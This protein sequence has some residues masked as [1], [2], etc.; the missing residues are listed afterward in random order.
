MDSTFFSKLAW[1]L[2]ENEQLRLDAILSFLRYEEARDNAKAAMKK[3]VALKILGQMAA[4]CQ[5][6]MSVN[7]CPDQVPTALKSSIPEVTGKFL[8]IEAYIVL[9][10]TR[11]LHFCDLLI[12]HP[13]LLIQIID[14]NHY[15]TE[16]KSRIL[17]PEGFHRLGLRL[18][19]YVSSIAKTQTSDSPL[20][21]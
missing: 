17:L 2:R 16:E 9:A 5:E 19:V 6:D 8:L 18:R 3:T 13:W 20:E 12:G 10:G 7:Y 21:L 11:S 1:A 14:P 15:L 4:S